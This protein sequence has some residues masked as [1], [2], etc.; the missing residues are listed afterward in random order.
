M[1]TATKTNTPEIGMSATYFIGSDAYHEIVV[2]V[3]RNGKSVLTLSADRVLGG[4]SLA[5]WNEM[6]QGIRS[7]R[8]R[9]A[10]IDLL[11]SVVENSDDDTEAMWKTHRIRNSGSYTLRKS[12]EFFKK[13]TNFGWLKL[14]SQ[15]SYLDP[16]F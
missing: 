8:A 9:K 14:N 2:D 7:M 5:D 3:T 12:G 13:G 10:W 16:S 6:P 15:Y 11:A 1:E 4:V